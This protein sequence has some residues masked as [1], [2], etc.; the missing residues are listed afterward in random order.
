MHKLTILLSSILVIQV[1]SYVGI[2]LYQDYK[3]NQ[4]IAYEMYSDDK[5][6]YDITDFQERGYIILTRSDRIDESR[7]RV[8]QFYEDVNG[9]EKAAIDIYNGE[10]IRHVFFDGDKI[11]HKTIQLELQGNK[12]QSYTSICSSLSYEEDADKNRMY[13]DLKNCVPVPGS[14]SP[15][16]TTPTGIIMMQE[17]KNEY[18]D[19]HLVMFPLD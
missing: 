1:L 9:G 8:F 13:F 18:F 2:M 19:S 6:D 14:L 10:S 17:A 4:Q 16:P 3:E 5:F 12:I 11:K 15:V 7:D